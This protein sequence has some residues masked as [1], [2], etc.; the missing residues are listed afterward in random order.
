MEAQKNE[1]MDTVQTSIGVM[2]IFFPCDVKPDALPTLCMRTGSYCDH[3]E[4]PVESAD[5][6][7]TLSC[8]FEFIEGWQLNFAD[9]KRNGV[10]TDIPAGLIRELSKIATEWARENQAAYA[11]QQRENF[12]SF[13]S[14]WLVMLDD[15]YVPTVKEVDQLL[16]GILVEFAPPKAVE[17][18]KKA[19]DAAARSEVAAD[20][21]KQ[22]LLAV[23]KM[24]DEC[25]TV[26]SDHA[27]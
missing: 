22:H 20:E 16:N 1:V 21:L 4:Q 25:E 3:C 11:T 6:E 10:K 18:M 26:D 27:P 24:E 13:A 8:D 9:F 19:R 7:V 2:E 23:G 12:F 5:R 15:D 17:M 14:G